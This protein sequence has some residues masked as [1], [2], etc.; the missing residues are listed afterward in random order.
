MSRR[1]PVHFRRRVSALDGL[2]DFEF[3]GDVDPNSLTAGPLGFPDSMAVPACWDATPIYAGRRGLAAYRTSAYVADTTPHELVFNAVQHWCRVFVDKVPVAEHAAGFTRFRAPVPLGDPRE[4][5]VVVL[6]DNRDDP[7]RSPLHRD[8][9]DWYQYGGI[10]GSVELH[11]LGDQWMSSVRCTT[12]RLEPEP[13]VELVIHANAISGCRV[14][15][16]VKV[17]GLR[18]HDEIVELDQSTNVIRRLIPVPG[19]GR[20]SLEQPCLHLLEVELGTDDYRARIGLRLVATDG[21]QL[22]VNGEPVVLFGVNR[23][24]SHPDHGFA[25]TGDHRLADIQRI[26]GLGANFVRG[27]HYPQDDGFLD[28][29]DERG[30]AVWCEATAWQPGA[31]QLTDEA[32]LSASEEH[33]D[34]MIAMAANHP[35]VLI[36]GC[37]NEG[38]SKDPACRPG[39]ARLLGR[40]REQDPTRP[41]TYATMLPFTAHEA[42]ADLCD[43]IAVNTYP[44]WYFGEISD[45]AGELDRI[46]SEVAA[47]HL[48]DRPLLISEIGA[49]A[50][51]GWNDPVGGRWSEVYQAKLIEAV[52]AATRENERDIAGV[53]LWVF[54]DFRVTDDDPKIIRRPRSHNNKGIFDELR[55]PKLGATV[56]QAATPHQVDGKDPKWRR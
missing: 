46:E 29:C 40:I 20:W 19:A 51:P 41:A 11:R 45:V 22:T 52:I 39:F 36:W 1:T 54:A 3:L 32:W 21:R 9:C 18:V 10:S 34:E 42:S 7:G 53:A 5:E 12:V 47:A 50:I 55:R 43:L 44:G 27:S 15:L 37:C 24:S 48:A 28:L 33:I 17:G 4:I 25:L 14:P 23:H 35:S 56:V 2:W 49:D 30:I 6:V 38:D 31:R 8:S 26:T 13:V 16:T